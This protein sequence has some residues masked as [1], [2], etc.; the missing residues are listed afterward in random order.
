MLRCFCP[1][2]LC[3][4]VLYYTLGGAILSRSVMGGD[5]AGLSAQMTHDMALRPGSLFMA[6]HVSQGLLPWGALWLL[7]TK[8]A[9]STQAPETQKRIHSLSSVGI[10]IAI[11]WQ[12]AHMAEKYAKTK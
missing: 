8:L 10:L 1:S 9:F 2:P 3:P 11:M 4:Y 7:P 12:H 5:K 6:S